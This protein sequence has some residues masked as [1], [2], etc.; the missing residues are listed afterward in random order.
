MYHRLNTSTATVTD[1]YHLYVLYLLH[2]E[3]LIAVFPLV[4]ELMLAS[5]KLQHKTALNHTD[6]DHCCMVP[7]TG[8][9]DLTSW[10]DSNMSGVVYRREFSTS[11]DIGHVIIRNMAEYCAT[12]SDDGG[13]NDLEPKDLPALLPMICWFVQ[14]YNPVLADIG[15]YRVFL[16]AAEAYNHWKVLHIDFVTVYNLKVHPIMSLHL[17]SLAELG[18]MNSSLQLNCSN[19][20][21]SSNKKE[22]TLTDLTAVPMGKKQADRIS[23]LT[24]F[25][26]A[27]ICNIVM[28]EERGVSGCLSSLRMF[29][30]ME[31]VLR[32]M[33]KVEKGACYYVHQVS[34]CTR[35]ALNM[36]EQLTVTDVGTSFGI[37]L[38]KYLLC[39][40]Y[41][42]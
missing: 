15:H 20:S 7:R 4:T 39:K 12:Y 19:I 34:R 14:E 3:W 32:M 33:E 21:Q 24:Q 17:H 9:I 23:E 8:V 40:M 37:G 1:Q 42:K 27:Q 11:M 30:V 13:D 18:Y 36:K 25:A 31:I 10:Q 26:L 35:A 38:H 22:W 5:F 28:L 29:S 16:G 6:R 2:L 41:C